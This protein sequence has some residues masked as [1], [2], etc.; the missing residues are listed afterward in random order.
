MNIVTKKAGSDSMAIRIAVD[1][2]HGG[3][4]N[5]AQYQGR[6]EKDEVLNLA[7]AVGKL[8]EQNGIDVIY[9]RTT[10]I[11]ETP[12]QKATEANEADADYFVSI[13]RNSSEVPGQYSGIQSLVYQN[14][15]VPRWMATN[16][17]NNLEQLGFRNIGIEERKNLVVL[18]RTKMPAVLVE[19]GFINSDIDN[20]IFDNQYDDIVAAIA[21]GILQTVQ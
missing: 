6:K 13:H 19:V 21:D 11:Y 1:A 12:F 3:F 20:Q 14:E 17:N 8:L 18:R 7:L 9:T 10:D 16:I 5:G 2:G 4:D 15:G